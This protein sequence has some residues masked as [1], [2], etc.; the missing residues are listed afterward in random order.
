VADAMTRLPSKTANTA[1]TRAMPSPLW[2][3]LP[4]PVVMRRPGPALAMDFAGGVTD[5]TRFPAASWRRSL[6]HALRQQLRDGSGYREPGGDQSLRLAISRY[7]GFSRALACSWQDVIV[8]QGAQQALDLLARVMI[9]P[10]DVVA[11]EDPCY[12]PARS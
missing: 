2:R 9:Q 8:T 5:T 6:L 1:A 7:L 4:E 11:V 3:R 12:P 10:G